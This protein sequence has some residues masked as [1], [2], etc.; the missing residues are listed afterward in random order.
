[1][2]NKS[3]YN[4]VCKLD[5]GTHVNGYLIDSAFTIAFNPMYEPLLKAVQDA[6]NEGIKTAGIDVRL[7]DVGAAIQ[8]VMES[9]EVEINGKTHPVLCVRNLCGH[10]ISQYRIHAG[11]S[12]PIVKGGPQTKMEEVG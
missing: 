3:E 4:D 9:N 12:V 6:T 7:C 10:S 5:F 1:M 8:E 2:H 11:K